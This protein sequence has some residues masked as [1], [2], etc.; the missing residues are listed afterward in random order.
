MQ[1]PPHTPIQ[2][3]TEIWT[4]ST[5]AHS[6]K[7]ANMSAMLDQ[8][9]APKTGLLDLPAELR[10]T[11]WE[12]ALVRTGPIRSMLPL[13]SRPHA[14]QQPSLTAVSRQIRAE[15]LPIFYHA[16]SFEAPYWYEL[17]LF[18]RRM[19]KANVKFLRCLQLDW[20]EYEL[21]VAARMLES[22]M[23]SLKKMGFCGDL[24]MRISLSGL[25]AEE[26]AWVGLEDLKGYWQV[27]KPDLLR[28]WIHKKTEGEE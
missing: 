10:N 6:S 8:T 7:A 18:V 23:Q 14:F 13:A 28:D 2:Q 17:K 25:M 3:S 21:A 20:T 11:I 19:D 16:N 9:T 24:K 27:E 5:T 1:S 15:T 22:N 26:T 4:T 12:Y